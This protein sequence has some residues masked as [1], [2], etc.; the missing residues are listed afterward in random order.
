MSLGTSNS[1]V[2][3]LLAMGFLSLA[4]IPPL[5]GFFGK[6]SIY[7]AL[8]KNYLYFVAVI[9]AILSLLTCVYYIRLVRFLWFS[10][11]QNMLPIHFFIPFTQFQAYLIAFMVILNFSIF[12]IQ[13]PLSQFISSLY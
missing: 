7:F 9:S 8:V 11:M 10:G 2:C 3:F 6:F 12:F 13:G 4:G 5:A 1:L